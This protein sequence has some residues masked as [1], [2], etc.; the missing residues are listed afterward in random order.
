MASWPEEKG[1]DTGVLN[2]AAL[3]FNVVSEIRNLRNSK[4]LS[5]KESLTLHIKAPETI[6]DKSFIAVIQKLSNLREVLFTKNSIDQAAT[7]LVGT[8]EFFVP[9]AGKTDAAKERETI[10]KE[11]E[12]LQGFL[13]SV[14]KKLSNEKFVNSAPPNVIEMERKKKADAEVKIKSLEGNLKGLS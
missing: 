13:V 4:G 14:E 2:H 1:Y 12:Y 6:L 10:L 11:L 9:L 3:S 5:P 8:T 7:F